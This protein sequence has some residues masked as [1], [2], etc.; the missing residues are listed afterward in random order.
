MQTRALVYCCLTS[1]VTRGSVAGLPL[2]IRMSTS[3]VEWGFGAMV[4]LFV[5]VVHGK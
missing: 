3:K 1:P 2:M 5:H 4:K